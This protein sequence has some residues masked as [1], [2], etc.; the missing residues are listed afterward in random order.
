MKN[1]LVIILGLVIPILMPFEASAG[2]EGYFTTYNHHIEKDESELM[3]MND[4]T[5]PSKFRREEG[6][7]NYLSHMLEIEYGLT[8][9]A[10]IEFM[11]EWFEELST[12]HAEFTGTRLEGRYRIFEEEKFINPMLYA[13]FEYLKKTTRFK[14]ETSGWIDPPYKSNEEHKPRYE[15]ILE[16]RL[17]LSKDIGNFNI[18]FNWINETDVH[19]GGTDFGYSFGLMHHSHHCG[20]GRCICN[21]SMPNCGCAHCKSSSNECN[22]HKEGHGR[23]MYG[24]ELFGGLGDSTRFAL[25]PD[26]Q[27]HYLQPILGF[28]LGGG[29][30][31]HLGAAIGLSKASDNLFRTAISFEF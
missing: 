10:A 17:V 23:I 9:Q 11:P 14:M 8:N 12:G 5:L 13:E 25:K 27:E 22:C 7:R 20:G 19:A 16:T 21:T 6:Q 30:M 3:L 24:V 28:D 29:R 1:N 4:F 2:N 18:A 31:L 26:R 15:R